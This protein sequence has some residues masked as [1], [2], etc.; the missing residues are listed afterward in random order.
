MCSRDFTVGMVFK[1]VGMYEYKLIELTKRIK[2]RSS[3][4]FK[5][6]IKA[7]GRTFL[8]PSYEIILV[9]YEV[10]CRLLAPF[11]KHKRKAYIANIKVA[12]IVIK[13]KGSN[14]KYR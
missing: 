8:Y 10:T 4:T 3:T 9:P 13:V 7:K 5:K 12:G 1:W 2:S 11:E 14:I 6:K